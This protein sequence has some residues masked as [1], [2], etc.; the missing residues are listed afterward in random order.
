M[1]DRRW[2][3]HV[4]FG[5][6]LRRPHF[7]GETCSARDCYA[8]ETK[9]RSLTNV[10]NLDKWPVKHFKGEKD[11]ITFSDSNARHVHHPHCNGLVITTMVANNMCTG[12]R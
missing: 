4:K 7:A 5:L 1:T 8:Q 12:F 11:D 2:R 3:P 10:D 6:S 9:E